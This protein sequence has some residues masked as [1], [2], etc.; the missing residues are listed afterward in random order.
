MYKIQALKKRLPLYK[1]VILDEIKIYG[2]GNL[3]LRQDL[4]I[5][6]NDLDMRQAQLKNDKDDLFVFG[7]FGDE[8]QM[9]NPLGIRGKFETAE[10]DLEDQLIQLQELERV[11]GAKVDNLESHEIL[12]EESSITMGILT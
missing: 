7:D 5:I 4:E 12:F 8:D 3:G 11:Y 6:N 2:E 10:E 9:F 1:K